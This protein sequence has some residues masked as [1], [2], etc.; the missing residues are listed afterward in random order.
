MSK[1]LSELLNECGKR[2]VDDTAPATDPRQALRELNSELNKP[3]V[4]DLTPQLNEVEK[5]LWL[6]NTA[7]EI[8]KEFYK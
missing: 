8:T 4:L 7:R 2:A 5:R 1:S 3:N 6:D